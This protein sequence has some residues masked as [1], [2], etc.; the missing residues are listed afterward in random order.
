[1][2]YRYENDAHDELSNFERRILKEDFSL[3]GLLHAKRKIYVSTRARTEKWENRYL[4]DS[5]SYSSL[6]VYDPR[7][8]I[9]R[10]VP[11]R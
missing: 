4:S 3:A 9:A 1:M 2:I 10:F 8:S 6:N 5:S 7:I 11:W